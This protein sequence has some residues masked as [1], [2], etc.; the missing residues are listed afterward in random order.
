MLSHKF[1]SDILSAPPQAKQCVRVTFR[2]QNGEVGSRDSLTHL[3]HWYPAK[4]FH[5]IPTAV[6]DNF[7]LAE[8]DVVLDLFCG[9]GTVLVEAMTRGYRAIG[10]DVNPAAQLI[11]R[12]K[13]TPI[14][15]EMAKTRGEQVIK[16]ARR[17]RRCPNLV[18]TLGYWFRPEILAV[19]EKLVVAINEIE[20][21]RHR[22]FLMISLS[23]IVRRCSLADPSIAPPVRL[24][25]LR[26]RHANQRYSNDLEQSLALEPDHVF[27]KFFDALEK[28][29]ARMNSFRER[30]R[31]RRG[32][33]TVL[34]DG[35]EAAATNLPPR[36]VDLILT[37]PPYCGAQKYVRSLKLEMQLLGVSAK[38]IDAADKQT[39]GGER[40]FIEKSPALELPDKDLNRL[41]RAVESR[42]FVRHRML[43][44]YLRYLSSFARE[45]SRILK[46]GGN[47]L[48]TFGTS[49]IAGIAFDAA[50]AFSDIAAHHGLKTICTLIDEIPSRGMI[51][52]R[53]NTAGVIRDERAVWLTKV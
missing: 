51:T 38:E 27:I 30:L 41:M 4:M 11:S 28:N 53:H 13:T 3:L 32:H 42:N 31:E 43:R 19:L 10:I 14:D 37:S 35:H 6:L 40:F 15:E 47:A 20:N 1:A 52:K 2:G 25:P 36:T 48:I 8:G 45:S 7:G 29:C 16:R 26:V 33:S 17:M 39:L 46:T 22:E 44:S 24:S 50:A 5:R 49:K 21:R 34:G 23:T 18:D 9:S 12:V